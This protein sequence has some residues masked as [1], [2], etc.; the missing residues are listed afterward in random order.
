VTGLLPVLRDAGA[1]GAGLSSFGP[2]IYAI[3][4]TGMTALEQAARSFMDEHGGGTTF[5][6][7]ARNSG[8]TVRV[9]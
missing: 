8:A 3:G 7:T 2:A 9:A 4:D 6:T 5:I 1:A